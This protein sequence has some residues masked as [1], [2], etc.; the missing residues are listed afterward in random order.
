MIVAMPDDRRCIV[1]GA[2][3][4]GLAA[5]WALTRRGWRV[6]VLEAAGAPGHERSGSKGDARIFR[7]GYPEPHYVEMAVLARDCWRDLETAT[8]APAPPRHR[9]GDAGRRGDA[10]CHRRRA[11]GRRCTRRAGL[12]RR[13]RP[14]AFPGSPPR[15]PCSSNPTRACWPPTS[16]CARCARRAASRSTRV[17]ASRR[18]ASRP[19]S[20]TVTTADGT[21]LEADIVVCC[22][23][24]ATLGLLGHDTAVTAAPSLPQVAYFA[25][26]TRPHD[27]TP[28]VFIEWGDDMLYGLPVPGGGP[29]A[30]HLQGVPPHTGSGPRRLRSGRPRPVRR[31]RPGPPG[32]A[33]RRRGAAPPL[34]RSAA[35][36]HGTLCLRQLRRHRLRSRSGGPDRRGVRHQRARVQVRPAAR[37]APGRSGRG[38]APAASTWVASA[39]TAEPTPAPG[40]AP[41]AR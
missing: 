38:R 39:C 36:G 5:A 33:D 10:P 1:V 15:G 16:A 22:A 40:P 27:V 23:G 32:A 2:G 34:T 30:R 26:A 7:L 8:G 25:R 20:V 41:E 37:R 19:D 18:C 29:H 6:R 12:G 35:G 14:G 21:V 13:R 17:A 31:P 11:G 24:P 3:L 4:L 28:P 9:P